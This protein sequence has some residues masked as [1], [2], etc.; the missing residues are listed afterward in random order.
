MGYGVSVKSTKRVGIANQR[1][2]M[3]ERKTVAQA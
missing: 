1:K 3:T 2:K